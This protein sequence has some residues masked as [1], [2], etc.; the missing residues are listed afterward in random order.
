MYFTFEPRSINSIGTRT[1]YLNRILFL[2]SKYYA[3]VGL[4]LRRSNSDLLVQTR[5]LEDIIEVCLP[6]TT[7]TASSSA[8]QLVTCRVSIPNT[9]KKNQ[10]HGEE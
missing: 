8:A 10:H 2:S 7:K 5:T 6:L 1:K 4:N 3:L 9:G